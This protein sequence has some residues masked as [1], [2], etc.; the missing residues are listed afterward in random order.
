M[1][2]VFLVAGERICQSTVAP[3]H[4]PIRQR[5]GLHELRVQDA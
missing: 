3:G 5:T 2:L 4:A 1:D